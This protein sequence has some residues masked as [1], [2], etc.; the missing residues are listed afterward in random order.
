MTTLLQL[1]ISVT[2]VSKYGK[3]EYS[4]ALNASYTF[5]P[6]MSFCLDLNDRFL[7]RPCTQYARNNYKFRLFIFRDSTFPLFFKKI[8][9]HTGTNGQ[10]TNCN[11]YMLKQG[12]PELC[13]SKRLILRNNMSN[14]LCCI[15]Q[16]GEFKDHAREDMSLYLLTERTVIVCHP[17]Y[18]LKY[19]SICKM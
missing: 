15:A 3:S 12:L 17:L 16:S 2:K 19:P 18:K 8:E 10:E 7:D 4:R 14:N 1:G 5:Q 11:L 13:V 6:L 9:K